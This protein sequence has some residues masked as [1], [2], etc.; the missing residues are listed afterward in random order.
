ML[1]V[2]CGYMLVI[3]SG[4]SHL[5]HLLQRIPYH[6]NHSYTLMVWCLLWFGE[7]RGKQ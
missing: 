3:L 1:A 6:E 2:W 7:G 4:I 5:Y